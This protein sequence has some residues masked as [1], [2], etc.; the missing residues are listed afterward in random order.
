MAAGMVTDLRQKA[1]AGGGCAELPAIIAKRH[2]IRAPKLE[3]SS[4]AECATVIG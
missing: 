1:Q 3:S 4:T 2:A